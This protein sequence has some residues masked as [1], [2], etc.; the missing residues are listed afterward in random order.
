MAL[1][2]TSGIPKM[3]GVFNKNK[4]KTEEKTVKRT[5][6]NNINENKKS[7]ALSIYVEDR[8]RVKNE[9]K[10]YLNHI[11]LDALMVAPSDFLTQYEKLV[12][13]ISD[14]VKDRISKTEH[15]S[16]IG[17]V[18]NAPIDNK[19]TN[20]V[21]HM[22]SNE[23]LKYEADVQNPN[24]NKL[25]ID[26]K[27]LITALVI[28]DIVGLGPLEPLYKDKRV[29]EVIANGP[30]D[31]QVE[32]DGGIEPIDCIKFRDQQHL[33]DLISRLYSSINKDWSLSN[34]AE[35]SRLQDFSRINAT[36]VN[37]N[38]MGPNLNIRKHE[39]DWVPPEKMISWDAGNKELFAYLGTCVY[40]GLSVLLVGSTGSGKTTA[41]STLTGYLP[42]NKRGVLI[43]RNLEL[44]PCPNKLFAASME[45]VHAKP[46]SNA[47]SITQRELV[48]ISTQMRPDLILLG[49]CTG[50]ETYDVLTAGN[51]GHQ[52]FTTIHANSGSDSINR[53]VQLASQTNL[54]KGDSLL[55]LIASS[56][57]IVV[58]V[59]RFDED[60]SRKIIEVS[61]VAKEPK[62]NPENNQKAL[63]VY[64]I[65][66]Y[67]VDPK[68]KT[69]NKIT[70]EWKKVGELSEKR[71]KM[72]RLD[73]STDLK[74]F[75]EMN[76]LYQDVLDEL[77]EKKNEDKNN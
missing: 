6:N 59:E 62:I 7:Y 41:L 47:R 52:I 2:K 39:D 18:R 38:P 32:I 27:N 13:E 69:A 11:S 35:R 49:E 67:K 5:I 12:E 20:E 75:E 53:L 19:Y 57:D 31:C 33:I 54:I 66:E 73:M 51:S 3:G 16:K 25:S 21:L 17:S 23:M 55:G 48:E 1:P 4:P 30:F 46:G 14:F 10:E 36:H 40:H 58:V 68:S 64:P 15:A 71:Q 65:W 22:I 44:Q 70:G 9:R 76:Y 56:I 29:T 8:E 34:P 50:P 63:P 45:E 43:E 24:Y 60:G 42:N 28:N 72:H 61:E 26:E 37:I 74:T 77:E